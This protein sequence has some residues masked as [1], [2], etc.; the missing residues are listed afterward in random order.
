M[1]IRRLQQAKARRT[2]AAVAA[3]ASPTV[4]LTTLRNP[5]DMEMNSQ[6]EQVVMNLRRMERPTNTIKALD[7]KREEYM[8]YCN[9]VYPHDPYRY[10][11]DRD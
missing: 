11:L 9:K 5:N 8:Q 7:S 6:M 2:A 3:A 4:T 1:M 10:T